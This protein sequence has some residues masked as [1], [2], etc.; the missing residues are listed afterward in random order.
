MV[1]AT[2]Q[3]AASVWVGR[4]KVDKKSKRMEL[5]PIKKPGGGNMTGGSVPGQIWKQFMDAASAAIDADNEPFLP[6]VKVGDPSKKGNGL[7]PLPPP[8]EEQ[9]CVLGGLVCPNGNG[10]GNG[11]NGNGNGG[12]GNGHGNGNG[13]DNIDP[14]FPALPGPTLPEPDPTDDGIGQNGG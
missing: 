8:P 14:T 10:N 6:N 7:D 1:G 2:R 4:E 12:N 9:D 13:G 5:M 11:G 3:I